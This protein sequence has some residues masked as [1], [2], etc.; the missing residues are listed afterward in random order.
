MKAPDLSIHTVESNLLCKGRELST[1]T[2][3][4]AY[5][6]GIYILYLDAVPLIRA[7]MREIDN[8]GHDHSNPLHTTPTA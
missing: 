8:Q 7:Y 2:V 6:C 4:F 1:E 5:S 3:T